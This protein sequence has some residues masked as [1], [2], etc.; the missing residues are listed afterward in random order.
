M[1]YDLW[2]LTIYEIIYEI[3]YFGTRQHSLLDGKELNK[4]VNTVYLNITNYHEEGKEK[5]Q[6]KSTYKIL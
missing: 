6:E 2:Q 5:G 3:P 4:E 1:T